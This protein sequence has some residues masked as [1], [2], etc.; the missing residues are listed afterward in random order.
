MAKGPVVFIHFLFIF[1]LNE[2]FIVRVPYELCE[3]LLDNFQ[4]RFS[5]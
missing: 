5:A 1:R 3:E 2:K 4:N